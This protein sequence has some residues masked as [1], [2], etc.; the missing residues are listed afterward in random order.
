[1]G[2]FQPISYRLELF[3]LD[4][5]SISLFIP[6]SSRRQI[7]VFSDTDVVLSGFDDD[8]DGEGDSDDCDEDDG[9]K[10]KLLS[11]LDTINTNMHTNL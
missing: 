2:Y 4:I 8:D 5:N 7:C 10:G 11:S 1:M 6:I 3:T 9:I